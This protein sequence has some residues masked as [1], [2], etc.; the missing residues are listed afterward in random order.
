MRNEELVKAMIGHA[1]E[2]RPLDFQADFDE[3]MRDRCESAVETRKAQLATTVFS[4]SDSGQDSE[5]E[6]E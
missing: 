3:V 5:G 6:N 2:S 1:L 4:G